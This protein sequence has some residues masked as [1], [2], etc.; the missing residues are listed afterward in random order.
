MM[1]YTLETKTQIIVLMARFDCLVAVTRKLQ[2]QGVT[3]IPTG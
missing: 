3:D 1:L 2:R